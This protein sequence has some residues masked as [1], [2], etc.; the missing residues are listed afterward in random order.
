MPNSR[1]GMVVLVFAAPKKKT[2][3]EPGSIDT[4]GASVDSDTTRLTQ[5]YSKKLDARLNKGTLLLMGYED[6]NYEQMDNK[7]ATTRLRSRP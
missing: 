5:F 2:K 7:A 1:A 4:K 3:K 6:S